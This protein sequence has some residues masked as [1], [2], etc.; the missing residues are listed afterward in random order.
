MATLCKVATIVCYVQVWFVAPRKE[1]PNVLGV[2]FSPRRILLNVKT[3]RSERS[4][5][6]KSS[7]H[8][9]HYR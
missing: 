4:M 9:A 5:F 6:Y 8:D 1:F 7:L 2:F 3:F